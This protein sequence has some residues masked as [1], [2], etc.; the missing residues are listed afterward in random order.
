M[1][2]VSEGSNEPSKTKFR[3]RAGHEVPEG[4]WGYSSTLSLTSELDGGWVVKAT[5]RPL[6]S[7]ERDPVLIL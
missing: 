3:P 1:A 7:W 5:P 2:G 6:Y 4:E